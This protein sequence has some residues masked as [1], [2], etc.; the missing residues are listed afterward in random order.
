MARQQTAGDRDT[1]R[2]SETLTQQ[3]PGHNSMV[4]LS[5]GHGLNTMMTMFKELQKNRKYAY[6]ISVLKKSSIQQLIP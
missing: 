5:A 4:P 2:E 6:S 3:N 1:N